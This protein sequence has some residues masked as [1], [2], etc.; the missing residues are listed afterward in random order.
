MEGSGYDLFLC[1]R[2]MENYGQVQ[3]D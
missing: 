3:L 1:G 2:T